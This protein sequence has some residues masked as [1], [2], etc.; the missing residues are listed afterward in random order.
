MSDIMAAIGNIQLSKLE[1]F[2]EKRRELAKYY[3]FYFKKNKFFT[4]LSRNYDEVVPHIY[5]LIMSRKINRSLFQEFL[6]KNN[7]QT[8]IHYKP[9]HLLN[10]FSN[11]NNLSLKNTE[12][13]YKN[14]ITLPLHPDLNFKDLDYIFTSISEFINQNTV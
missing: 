4:T 1:E 12:S 6:L 8:G 11:Q 14:I 10:F 3:D 5:P 9:N 13:I 7:I 2:A